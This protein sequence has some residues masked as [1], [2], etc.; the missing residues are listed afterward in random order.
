[1]MGT[2][3]TPPVT[4]RNVLMAVGA[5]GLAVGA[6]ACTSDSPSSSG[7]TVSGQPAEPQGAARISITVPADGSKDVPYGTEI[8]FA[9]TDAVSSTVELVDAQGAKVD[10]EMHPDGAGWLPEESLNPQTTYTATITAIDA[11]GK[12]TV[13]KST[14]T[15]MAK[16]DKLLGVSSF[17][18]DDAVVGVGM[19]MIFR[20]GRPVAQS[21]RAALQR[22][23]LVETEPQQEGI[24]TW[25]TDSELHWRPKAFWEPGTKIFIRSRVGGLP[26]GDGWY[27]RVDITVRCSIGPSLV[28]TVDDKASPKVMKVI[29]DGTV[30]RSIPVSL[31]RPSMP[32]SSGTTVIIEK[33]EKTVFDTRSD[34]NP[35]NR[36]RTDIQWAQRLTWGGEFI[37][38]APWSVDDQGRRNVSH[39]CVNMSTANAKWL[40]EQTL[41]GTPLTI[42]GTSRPLE[43]GNGWTDFTR[44]WEQYVQGSAIPYV[45]PTGGPEESPSPSASPT[46]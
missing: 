22:R 46:A 11:N 9:T 25:Y 8:V 12:N 13:V 35:A 34:P 23:L 14:F 43:Y 1:M 10:G 36:Y 2:M 18:G 15:T 21:Q 31:G 20:L 44:P 38:A 33:L 4:R 30:I 29:K 17:L 3:S 24:W 45:A 42:K 41:M 6:A 5:A 27:G 7:G 39:G 16:P 26:L 32:S 40:F 37:H 28:L 19:P